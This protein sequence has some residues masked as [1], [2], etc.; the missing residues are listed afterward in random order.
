VAE[1][2]RGSRFDKNKMYLDRYWHEDDFGAV[3]AIRK[4]AEKSGR[5]MV[6]LALCWLLHHTPIECIILGASKLEHLTQNLAAAEE[7]PLAPETVADL[8]EVWTRLRGV[9]PKY[10]R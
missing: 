5:S 1:P 4:I 2:I 7:G 10:N 9:T 3:E 8:D 6:S